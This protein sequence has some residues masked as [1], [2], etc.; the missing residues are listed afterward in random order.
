M[1]V[2]LTRAAPPVEA[3]AAPV[4][5]LT[6]EIPY[7][8]DRRKG[9]TVQ[10]GRPGPRGD[11]LRLQRHQLPQEPLVG[12]DSLSLGKDQPEA[13]LEHAHHGGRRAQQPSHLA[14]AVEVRLHQARHDQRGAARYPL[15]A[16]HQDAPRGRR[17]R[18][19]GP[20]HKVVHAVEVRGDVETGVVEHLD[21]HVGRTSPPPRA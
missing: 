20:K 10:A 18:V 2:A 19:R 9:G 16:V 6:P 5:N 7:L 17:R 4:I 1:V 3:A 21:T 13:L 11:Q 14:A 12:V 15:S 8:L